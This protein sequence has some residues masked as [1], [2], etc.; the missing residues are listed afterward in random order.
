RGCMPMKAFSANGPREPLSRQ[1]AWGCLTTNLTL[2][3]F[4]SLAAGRASG[5]AQAAL[6]ICGMA[7]TMIFGARFIIWYFANR[8]RLRDSDVDPVGALG[9]LWINVRWPVL[10]FA[11]FFVAWLWAL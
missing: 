4:G 8:G 5:Y 11:V 1:T 6:M 10:G 9:E 7:I 2:P 3:G